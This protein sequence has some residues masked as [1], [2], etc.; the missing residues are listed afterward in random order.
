MYVGFGSSWH[1][2][3]EVKCDFKKESRK[4]GSDQFPV[5]FFLCT[6]GVTR[7]VCASFINSGF[8][9]ALCFLDFKVYNTNYI[10]NKNIDIINI[11][12]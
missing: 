5:F 11:T 12:L 1:S 8:I 7:R 4:I 3:L 2:I 9:T 6:W 10:F